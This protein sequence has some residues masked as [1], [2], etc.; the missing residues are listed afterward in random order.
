MTGVAEAHVIVSGRVQGVWF[1][2]NT[3][4]VAAAAGV[5]G[6]VRNLPDRRVEAVLQG[7][8]PAVESVIDFMRTGPPG[9][10]VIDCVVSWGPAGERFH[11]FDIRY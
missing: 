8:R 3:Q 4:R 9:A 7:E 2:G 11:G 6:W 5:H 1:R 10:A